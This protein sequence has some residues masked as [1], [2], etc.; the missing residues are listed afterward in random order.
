MNLSSSH[1]DRD[2]A[3]LSLRF[4]I[5]PNE[6][7]PGEEFRVF[8]TF[9]KIYWFCIDNK[10]RKGKENDKDFLDFVINY[11]QAN[12]N[13][14]SVYTRPV[15]EKYYK[16]FFK[17][18]NT[19]PT[20]GTILINQTFDCMIM[21]KTKPKDIR[22]GLPKGKIEQSES[23]YE[24]AVRETEEEIGLNCKK[25][26]KENPK[27]FSCTRSSKTLTIY[28]VA[29]VNDKEN[30][31]PTMNGEVASIE[32]VPINEISKLIMSSNDYIFF[33]DTYSILKFVNENFI[34]L[35]FVI[36]F[37]FFAFLFL[38]CLYLG[39]ILLLRKEEN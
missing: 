16:E 13:L 18:I 23:S 7:Q 1:V 20:Y 11:C 14:K 17:Y 29:G 36:F 24:C 39:G 15:L 12:D 26:M 37:F 27:S 22:W 2:I 6:Y 35:Y 33:K 25:Y 9:Q 4:L 19:I 21:I 31:H 5:D 38:D 34:L 8:F 10:I 30:L 28:V 3:S 32:W